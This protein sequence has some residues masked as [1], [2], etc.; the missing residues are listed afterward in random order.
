MNA[1]IRF[2]YLKFT[3]VCCKLFDW[4]DSLTED[5]AVRWREWKCLRDLPSSTSPAGDHARRRTV[6]S[7]VL[8]QLD[9]GRAPLCPSWQVS[10]II[11]NLMIIISIM[12][13]VSIS[14]PVTVWAVWPRSVSSTPTSWTPGQ[15][16]GWTPWVGRTGR[17]MTWSHS[18]NIILYIPDLCQQRSS[19]TMFQNND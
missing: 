7:C 3:S 4:S 12:T 16:P 17:K 11:I 18:G 14:W 5:A 13:Q 9:Q 2:Y 8:D 15:P 10:I 1:W 6:A 19:L